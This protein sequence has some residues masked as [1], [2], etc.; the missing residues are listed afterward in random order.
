MEKYRVSISWLCIGNVNSIEK[1]C[2]IYENSPKLIENGCSPF[3]ELLLSAHINDLDIRVTRF[4]MEYHI[5]RL[6][7]FHLPASK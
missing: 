4:P 7:Q 5:M 6:K 2:S 1:Y 3:P